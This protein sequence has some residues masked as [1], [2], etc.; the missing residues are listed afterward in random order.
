MIAGVTT[1]L[2]FQL[3]GEVVSRTLGLLV[4]GPVVGM[5][6]LLL[7]LVLVPRAAEAIRPV[8][9][10]LLGH[11]S[12]LFVPAGVGVVGHLALFGS[13]GLA[14]AAAIL[15]STALAILAGAFAFAAVNRLTGGSDDA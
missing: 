13:D 9:Q 4:P 12:L 11:L 3:A 5:A 6:G 2:L 14:L 8:A 10:G 7:F 1:L 15:V